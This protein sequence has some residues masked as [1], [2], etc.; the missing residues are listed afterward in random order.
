MTRRTKGIS[1]VELFKEENTAFLK[2][3]QVEVCKKVDDLEKLVKCFEKL[4]KTKFLILVKHLHET[5]DRPDLF[6]HHVLKWFMMLLIL[7]D[8][9]QLVQTGK[10]MYKYQTEQIEDIDHICPSRK[11]DFVWGDMQQKRPLNNISYQ[12]HKYYFDDFCS[13]LKKEDV[14]I[15][16]LR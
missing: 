2:E 3:I 4:H 8:K 11:G 5:K 12:A 13:Y 1:D 7:L 10:Y 6:E 15:Y 16:I 9:S 14:S